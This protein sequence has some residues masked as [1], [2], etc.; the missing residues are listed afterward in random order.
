MPSSS[1]NKFTRHG[2]H[3]SVLLPRDSGDLQGN[4]SRHIARPT[5]VRIEG[6]NAQNALVFTPENALDNGLL[7]GPEFVYLAPR[8]TVLTEVLE[9]RRQSDR[10]WELAAYHSLESA[11]KNTRRR[12]RFWVLDLNPAFRWAGPIGRVELL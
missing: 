2:A 1:L 6:D 9:E 7:V 10:E 3:L 5:L 12:W 4:I 11:L 8:A